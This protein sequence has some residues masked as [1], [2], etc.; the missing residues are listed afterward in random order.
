MSPSPTPAPR[1]VVTVAVA[2]RQPEPDVSERR[3][4]LYAAAVSRHGGTPIVLDAT[5]TSGER[6]EAFGTMDGLLISG[7][8]DLHPER[9]GRADRGSTTVEIDRDALEAEAWEVAQSRSRPVLGICR[10]FQAINVFSGGTL[11]QHVDGHQGPRWGKGP[12]LVHPLRVAPGT[13]LARILFPTN[14]RGGV[15]RVNSYHHQAV[16]AQDL[17][18]GLVANAWASSPAGDLVE[19]LEA[20]DGRFVFALQCH[21]ERQESTPPAFE[22]LFSVFVDAARGPADRR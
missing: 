3:N 14:S 9:Y 1:V 12:A 18:P 8:A 19:G 10:G 17:A 21:P 22:R 20:A 4:A 2:A 11:L 6:A 16:R 13:R 15:L 5:S 7:G